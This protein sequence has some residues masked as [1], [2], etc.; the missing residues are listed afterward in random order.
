MEFPG[1]FYLALTEAQYDK[2]SEEGGSPGLDKYRDYFYTRL[3]PGNADIPFTNLGEAFEYSAK[4]N[5]E[6]ICEVLLDSNDTVVSLIRHV[7][8]MAEGKPQFTV[9]IKTV[10]KLVF[11]SPKII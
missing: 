10:V 11:E 1:K 8:S 9:L 4:N 6:Y 3:N 2:L 7:L 5:K